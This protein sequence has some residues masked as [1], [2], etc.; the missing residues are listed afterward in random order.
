MDFVVFFGLIGVTLLSYVFSYDIACQW[1]RKLS[2]RMQRLPLCMQINDKSLEDATFVLPKL[3]ILNHG[4]GCQ[5]KFSLNWL[6]W[7]ARTNGEDPE[8]WWAHINPISMSIKE[9]GEGSQ[10][11]AVDDHACGWNWRKIVGFGSSLTSQMEA[12][13]IT[14]PKY[15]TAAER[16]TNTFTPETVAKWETMVNAWDTDKDMPGPYEEPQ[17]SE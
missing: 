12:A 16:L 6:C 5:S 4:A 2:E 10:N 9:M 15:L 7:S 1:S 17:S 13:I 8:R 14:Y 3:H 11:N